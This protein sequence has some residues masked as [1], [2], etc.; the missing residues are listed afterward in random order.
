M[1]IAWKKPATQE[2]KIRLSG[3]SMKKYSF[4]VCAE[5]LDCEHGGPQNGG[6]LRERPRQPLSNRSKY[7]NEKKSSQ[8]LAREALKRGL[9]T[10]GK[11]VELLGQRP[12]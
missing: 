10:A 8:E 4:E 6:A 12:P 5:V 1:T 11:G 2:I 9:Y 3:Q 7:E